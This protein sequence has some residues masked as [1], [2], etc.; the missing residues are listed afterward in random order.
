[1]A[2]GLYPLWKSLLRSIFIMGSSAAKMFTKEL[3]TEFLLQAKENVSENCLETLPG[4]Y[5]IVT[6]RALFALFG[7]SC[8]YCLHGISAA[9][10]RYMP[11]PYPGY[12]YGYAGSGNA[13]SGC[14]GYGAP[15]HK[16]MSVSCFLLN[17]P[18]LLTKAWEG[19]RKN[20]VMC[21]STYQVPS[22]LYINKACGEMVWQQRP[23]RLQV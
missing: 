7:E 6:N 5:S 2:F 20:V 17:A 18:H 16:F 3:F 11:P 1:M 15:L 4:W 23:R 21:L 22:R 12:G 13:G 8:A 19:S 9:I 14:P 10:C